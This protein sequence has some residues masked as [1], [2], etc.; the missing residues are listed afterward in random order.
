[1]PRNR[2]QEETFRRVLAACMETMRENSF[3]DLTVRMVAA[4]AKVA[5]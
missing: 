4:R 5:P 3:A 2:R 1:M